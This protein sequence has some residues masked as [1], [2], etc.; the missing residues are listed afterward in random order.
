MI[1]REHLDNIKTLAL[2]YN[3]AAPFKHVVFH[4]FLNDKIYSEVSKEFNLSKSN[5]MTYKHFSQDKYALTDIK[6]MGIQTQKLINFLASRECIDY[7]ESVTGIKNLKF[8][9]SLHNGGLHE[10]RRDGHLTLH[11]DFN[12]H[13]HHPKWRRRINIIIYLNETWHED[14]GGSLELWDDKRKNCIRKVSPK[15][16]K[17]I[18]FDTTNSFHG[19]PDPIKCPENVTRKSLAIF[20]FTEEEKELE[21]ISTFYTTRASDSVIRK[22]TIFFD[23]QLVKIYN[24]LLRRF[25]IKNKTIEKLLIFFFKNKNDTK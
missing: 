17:C 24:F 13:P 5:T 14:W 22:L 7:L 19:Y 10:T 3:N 15:K 25:N 23:R 11:R 1:N 8:D 12:T 2:N 18:L 6:E 20:Y 4:N 16:N 21:S 9:P